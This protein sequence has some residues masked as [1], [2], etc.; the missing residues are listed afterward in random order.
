MVGYS[1]PAYK[2]LLGGS[3]LTRTIIGRNLEPAVKYGATI[4]SGFNLPLFEGVR[5]SMKTFKNWAKHEYGL[6]RRVITLV[7]AAFFFLLTFPYLLVV[8]AIKI[9]IHYDLPGFSAGTINIILGLVLIVAGFFL[10]MWSIW[11]QMTIGRG[12]PLPMMPTQKLVVIPPFT[13]CRNP[14]T[15]GTCIGYSGIGVL[16]G[17]FSALVIVITFTGLLLLY[18]KL[19]EEKELEVRFGDEYVQ[20][21]H[22]TPFILPRLQRRR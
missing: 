20:Y 7:F 22:S 18:I 6:R 9:D 19:I 3:V 1:I 21:M 13:Y 2:S 8:S 14:M 12:T 16:I 11:A 17:S 15:L 4:E 5:C 10:G